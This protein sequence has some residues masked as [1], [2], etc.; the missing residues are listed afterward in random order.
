MKKK[1][2]NP[3]EIN[4]NLISLIEK[5]KINYFYLKNKKDFRDQILKDI[6]LDDDVLDMGKA[7]RDKHKKIN[8]RS[9]ETLDVNDFGD[10]PDI[11]CDI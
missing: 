10:Y 4:K 3:I 8:C 5:L 7:M 11:I 2:G 6:R 1:V 9:L